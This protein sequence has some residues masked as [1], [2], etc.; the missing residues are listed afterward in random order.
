MNTSRP[1]QCAHPDSRRRRDLLNLLLAAP[2]AV[3][4][5]GGG[6]DAASAAPASGAATASTGT[7]AGTGGTG[8]AAAAGTGASVS[9]APAASTGGGSGATGTP[10]ATTA[11]SGV[12]PW[13]GSLKGNVIQAN[14]SNYLAL[15]PTLKPGD[16]LLLQAGT[17]DNPADPPGLPIFDLNGTAAAPIVITGPATG[18]M[19]LFIGRA[20]HN[21]IRLR[22]AS[23]V[24]VRNVAVDGR[25][26]GGF[27]VATQGPAHHITIEGLDIRGCGGDQQNVGIST[28]GQVTWNWTIRRN[29]I[30]G[31]GTGMY[32]GNSDGSS[33]FVAGLIE[34]NLVRDTIGYNVQVK[35]QNPRPALAGLPTGTSVTVIR[36]NVFSKSSSSSTGSLARPNLLVGH[37]PLSGTGVDDRYEI[38]G[39]FFWQNPT[40]ALFQGE[41]NLVLHSNVM[42]SDTGAAI[43]IQPHN[44][45]PKTVTVFCNTVVARTAGIV[46]SGAAP[47]LVQRVLG[48]AV[49]AGTPLSGGQQSENVN[50]AF[51]ASSTALVAPTGAIGTLDL[52]PRT[53]T[54]RRTAIDP[55]SL[56]GFL[57]H[58]RDFDGTRRGWD[59]RGAY[60]GEGQ[61]PG[62]RLA[63]ASRG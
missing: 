52:Y 9:S 19:P 5:C 24:V 30:V 60:A 57:D 8:G 61:N 35:H 20:T 36:R 22:N 43:V 32:L 23:H 6:G 38:Y 3:A 15:L 26:L 1:D 55:S 2:W 25:D 47:G 12:P 4:G 44:D 10:A 27:G 11:G 51:A 34:G 41:G 59:F 63:L 62:W 48:N 7:G 49:F 54:L 14:P 56:S 21:T 42:V 39:N 45:V 16:T 18:A 40:E 58:D 53:G 29:T 31:A 33:Q 37:S 46:V 28:T 13:D 17:Y 50:G